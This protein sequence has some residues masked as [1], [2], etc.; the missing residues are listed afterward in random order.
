MVNI[1][2]L[3]APKMQLLTHSY[4]STVLQLMKWI[5]QQPVTTKIS[6]KKL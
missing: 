3:I 4:T 5:S 6:L 2:K 1:T